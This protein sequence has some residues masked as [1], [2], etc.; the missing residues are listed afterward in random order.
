M[1]APRSVTLLGEVERT[2]FENEDTGFRVLS[3]H[4]VEGLDGHRRITV[5]GVLGRVAVGTRVRVSG[6]LEDDS[7]RGLRVR[8]DSLVVVA[9]ETL[10]GIERYL[11]S[12]VIAGVGP[13]F[14]RRIVGAFG[15]ETLRV[16]DTSPERLAEL[17]GLGKA[18]VDKI[19]AS[20]SEHRRLSNVLLALE[21]HGVSAALAERIVARF[22]DK[23]VEVVVSAPYRLALEVSGIGFKT[24]DTIARARGIEP[25]HP[26]RCQAG[27]LHELGE[28]TGRGHVRAA[29]DVL[30]VRA[31]TLLGV[32][33]EHV[34]AALEALARAERAIIEG[35]FVYPA[36]LHRAELRVAERMRTLLD[37][38]DLPVVDLDGRIA[39]FEEASGIKLAELQRRAVEAAATK[40]IVV[41]TGGP[42][43]GKTTI[44]RAMISV[45][46]SE[47]MRIALA[48]PT[49]RAAKRLTESTGQMATTIHRLL[50]VGPQGSG[51]ARN[52]DNPL[53]V[54]LLIIDE[55][56]MLDLHLTESL[57]DAVP[58]AA[59][60]VFVG[61]V[62]QLPSVG[63]GAV[64]SDLIDSRAVPVVRLDVVF[65]QA[66]ESGI[67]RA[68][69][70]I[71]HGQRPQSAEDG[72][73]EFFVAK[74]KDGARAEEVVAELVTERIPKRFGFDSFRDVQVLTPMHRGAAGTE[75]L[76]ARLRALLR[77]GGDS[78]SF[79][80]VT[81]GLGD[82]VLQT[83]NDYERGVFNGDVGEVTAVDV[84][85]QSLLVRFDQDGPDVEYGRAE[86]GQL[87]LAYAT[88][89]HKS[90]GSE[91]PVV[92][93]VML[94]SHFIMLSRNLLYT[95]VT[96]ARKLCVLVTDGRALGLALSE[97]NK[98]RRSTGLA[99]RL[100][101]SVGP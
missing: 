12:G 88:S 16:L 100:A 99:A 30:L 76:N 57:L 66:E 64:L 11:G 24:A 73:G 40:K 87:V 26:E 86:L 39:R 18:R 82:K 2:L 97:T 33:A 28:V 48:A 34:R 10:E 69:H 25:A 63:P 59:R 35:E 71:L 75:S 70:A 47:R 41:V 32:E 89:I 38:P 37:A 68:S 51:F 9:P 29:R 14:A 79:G 50:E 80:G 6:R 1:E 46:G 91:Y 96:R 21:G 7:K 3:L 17:K 90:Q 19:R 74:V 45:V 83:K 61:D 8:A 81:I 27:L 55:A 78:L 67:V 22:G 13:G 56:S 93:V 60:V 62:D 92:V 15:V 72:K 49:G 31:A 5:V 36:R 44:V 94:A 43:V 95:A 4:K 23:A 77:A 54:D 65:R 42:G 20:W 98:E 53:A 84:V 101:R 85:E 52:E 58:N